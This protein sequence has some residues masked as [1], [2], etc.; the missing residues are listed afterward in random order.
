MDTLSQ[1]KHYYALRLTPYPNTKEKTLFCRERIGSFIETI[2]GENYLFGQEY[3]KNFHF[4]IIFSHPNLFDTSKGDKIKSIKEILY[5]TFEV[6][7]KKEGNPTYSLE[8]VRSLEEALCYAVKDDDY[9][10]SEQWIHIA[11][12]AHENSFSKAHSLKRSL[13]D[14]T[15]DYM[16]GEINDR[17]L[18]IGLGQSRADLGLPLSI[19]WI[20]EMTLSIQC[21]KD[22]TKLQTIWE[23]I[24]IKR[25]LK[26]F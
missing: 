12:D 13:G 19:K 5:L 7:K 10:S 3:E 21:K 20:E 11:N 2:G 25:Q 14:L 18:W 22:P 1:D 8:E 24:E 6:P 23:D 4:H 26:S 9:E 16:K 17:Q 15:D